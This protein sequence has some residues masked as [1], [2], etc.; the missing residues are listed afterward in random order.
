MEKVN[1][2][3]SRQNWWICYGEVEEFEFLWTGIEAFVIS[4]FVTEGYSW[5]SSQNIFFFIASHLSKIIFSVLQAF[6]TLSQKRLR[7]DILDNC[8]RTLPWTE[9]RYPKE[10]QKNIKLNDFR[11]SI[12]LNKNAML[13]SERHA[14]R[15]MLDNEK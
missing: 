1:W 5:K 13:R 7:S 10:N 2:G 4:F 8:Q 11:Y 6:F 12:P 9:I 15:W 3:N 14:V